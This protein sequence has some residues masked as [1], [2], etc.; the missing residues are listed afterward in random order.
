MTHAEKARELFEEGYNCAQAVAGAFAEDTG[1]DMDTIARLMSSFGGGVAH[2]RE[3]CGCVSGMSLIFGYLYGY[4]DPKADKEK[5]DQYVIIKEMADQFKEENG[6]LTCRDLLAAIKDGTSPNPLA[7]E[8]AGLQRPCAYLVA[9][10]AEILEA[11]MNELNA[12]Q[13]ED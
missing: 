11:K 9:R 7:K 2:M 3:V 8:A 6:G 4:T 13:K 1:M 12:C 10:M 5:A